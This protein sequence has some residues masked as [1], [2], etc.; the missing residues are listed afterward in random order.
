MT[1]AEGWV[2]IGMKYRSFQVFNVVAVAPYASAMDLAVAAE[3]RG[4]EVAD[5]RDYSALERWLMKCAIS[6][7][8]KS[9]STR[10][11]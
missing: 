11:E 5:G 9:A 4:V 8:A 6:I 7:R 2:V 10:R 1:E 3:S